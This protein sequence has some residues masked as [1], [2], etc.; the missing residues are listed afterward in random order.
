MTPAAR[1]QA[2]IEILDDILGGRPAEQAL[3]SWARRSRYAGSKDRAAIRDHVFDALRARRSL[4]ARGGAVTGRGLMIG[5]LR[6]QG[7]EISSFFTGDRH[8]PDA[9]SEAEQAAGRNPEPGAEASDI[10]DWLWPEFTASLGESAEAAGRI[11]Q[12]RAPLH[13]RANLLK[14]DRQTAISLLAE[15][16]VVAQ[17]HPA[18]ATAME[19]VEGARKVAQTRAYQQGMVELQDAASQAIAERVPLR[20]GLRVL[21]FCAGGGGKTLALAARVRGEIL[22]HDAAPQR[23]RDLPARATRAGA[24]VRLVATDVVEREAPFDLILADVPCS[25]SGSWRRAPDGKW[26]LTP[27]RLLELTRIQSAILRTVSGL[28]ATGGQVA[29]ATC[30]MLRVENNNIV[31]QFLSENPGWKQDDRAQWTVLDGTDGFFLSVLTRVA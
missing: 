20:S 8:A 26:L 25:G 16:G 22:A 6:A 24:Q 27:E 12:R 29:Y 4:A 31:E 7:Q 3:T 28:V 5:L 30:S 18:C 23:M 2:A 15:D 13:L 10:P 14:T 9:L 21:D 17:P 11:M 1:I 19:V